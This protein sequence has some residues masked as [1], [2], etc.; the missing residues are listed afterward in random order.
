MSCIESGEDIHQERTTG[1]NLVLRHN[2]YG[3][4]LA[5]VGLTASC[6][7]EGNLSTRERWHLNHFVYEY[8]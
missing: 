8:H 1:C 7:A 6:I 4:L 3:A 5:Q 2:N